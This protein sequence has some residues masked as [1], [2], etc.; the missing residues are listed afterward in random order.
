MPR[1]A[2]Y[3]QV[4]G[5]DNLQIYKFTLPVEKPSVVH[6]VCEARSPD[7]HVL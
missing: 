5:L 6:P 3:S 2:T 4:S 1:S 7:P